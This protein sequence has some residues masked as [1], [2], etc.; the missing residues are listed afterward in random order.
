MDFKLSPKKATILLALVISA[1]AT[2]FMF[3]KLCLATMNQFSLIAIRFTLATLLLFL[4]FHR[5][6]IRHF[7]L[8]SLFSG[9]IIGSLFFLVLFLEHSGLKT[10]NASTASFIENMA[11]VIVPLLECLIGRKLPRAKVVLCALLAMLG[12][13]ILKLSGNG[14]SFTRGELHLFGAACTYAVAIIVTSRL[15]QKGDAFVT[16]FFQVT[17]TGLCAWFGVLFSDG[18]TL[19]VSPSQW[20]MIVAL[21]IVCTGFGFTLQPVAQRNIS[22]ETAGAFCALGPL[23]ASLMS[24]LF[25]HDPVSWNFLLGG[26]LILLSIAVDSMDWEKLLH[27]RK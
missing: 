5:T 24:I 7:S 1:R 19:P 11:I 20:G 21:A 6:I 23:V 15:S 3:S 10:T 4:I 14:F 26:A 13:G 22:S 9:M 8:H 17:T 27:G 12:V 25:L 2:S 18:I 16:G